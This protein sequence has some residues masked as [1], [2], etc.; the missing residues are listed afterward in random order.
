MSATVQSRRLTIHPA[1]I[2][3]VISRQAGSLSKAL[4][5]GVMNCVDAGSTRCDITLSESEYTIRDDGKGF[6][7][8]DEIISFFETF[9]TP[10][11]EGD[12]VFGRYRMGRGQGFSFGVNRWKT[13]CFDMCV[14]IKGRGLDYDLIANPEPI[15]AGCDI[16]VSLYD[17]LS[18]GDYSGTIREMK[19]LCQWIPIPVYLNG[20]LI[21]TSIKDAKWDVETDDF[22]IKCQSTGGV[23]VY[24]LGA[25]VT[26]YSSFDFGG[27]NGTVVSKKQLQ[28]NFARNDILVAKCEIFKDIKAK[29]RA[30]SN[31]ERKR[32]NRLTA[33]DRAA[34]LREAYEGGEIDADFA[35]KKLIPTFPSQHVTLNSVIFN[36]R[37]CIITPQHDQRLVDR[38]KNERNGPVLIKSE[39]MSWIGLDDGDTLGLIEFFQDAH[40]KHLE[41]RGVFPHFTEMKAVKFEDLTQNMSATYKVIP[42]HKAKKG[43]LLALETLRRFTNEIVRQLIDRGVETGYRQ[44]QVGESSTALAWT[45]GHSRVT[46]DS[47]YLDECIKTS[48]GIQS[49]VNTYLHELMHVDSDEESHIHDEDFYRMFHDVS[50]D[51]TF[52]AIGMSAIIY[53]VTRASRL[54]IKT[55]A[56]LVREV[57]TMFKFAATE[58]SEIQQEAA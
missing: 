33:S 5:E 56:K 16:H 35:E 41:A 17:R 58:D 20:A 54:G 12:A 28:V 22:V 25:Y 45:D 44:L 51:P 55:G 27:F 52:G 29:L 49:L 40:R 10:H 57:D 13:G 19:S 8:Q 26:T 24:N 6:R 37:F 7:D 34:I 42:S 43:Q 3:D 21:S 50:L 15:F 47:A 36:R 30:M 11:T 46:F 2:F 1:M 23:K 39:I 18:P 4:L 14:D 48:G 38:L 53:F 32:S 31:H 9:G